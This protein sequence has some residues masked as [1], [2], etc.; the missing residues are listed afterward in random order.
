MTGSTANG[1]CVPENRKAGARIDHPA[2]GAEMVPVVALSGCVP[3]CLPW[4]RRKIPSC[5]V[6]RASHAFRP[7]IGAGNLQ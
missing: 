5:N 7:M 1:V 6:H 4:F 2:S 3:V